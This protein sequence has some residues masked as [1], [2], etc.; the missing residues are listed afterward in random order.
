MD[1]AAIVDIEII[2]DFV[3]FVASTGPRVEMIRVTHPHQEIVLRFATTSDDDNQVH[4]H[5]RMRLVAWLYFYNRLL[6]VLSRLTHRIDLAREM[7]RD[8]NYC[9]V[10]PSE[11]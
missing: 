3:S 9:W 1:S 7:V 4:I 10:V 8:S 2:W 5:A 6:K 11:A